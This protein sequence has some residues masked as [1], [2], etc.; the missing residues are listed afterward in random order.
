MK[1]SEK[2]RMAIYGAVH[3]RLMNLRIEVAKLTN[4]HSSEFGRKLDDLIYKAQ[5]DAASGAVKAA[6][7]EPTPHNG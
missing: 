2:R 1:L 3:D 5:C 7:G 4:G 6:E